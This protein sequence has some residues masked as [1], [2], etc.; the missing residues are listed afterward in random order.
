MYITE[1]KA[2][3]IILWIRHAFSCTN[4]LNL[5]KAKESNLVPTSQYD[6]PSIT[7]EGVHQCPRAWHKIITKLY[8][9]LPKYFILNFFIVS[10]LFRTWETAYF[11]EPNWSIY[12]VFGI[13]ELENQNGNSP[14][15]NWNRA[16][17]LSPEFASRIKLVPDLL[18]S[19]TSIQEEES[20]Q[21]FFQETLP[22][23]VKH[24]GL[25]KYNLDTLVLPIVSHGRRIEQIADP[26][27]DNVGA[28]LQEVK[29][30]DKQRIWKNVKN[31]KTVFKGFPYKIR[32]SPDME[33]GLSL[34]TA[35]M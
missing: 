25:S 1:A 29:F 27:L 33:A 18:F 30:S 26:F 21:V 17:R 16:R 31:S 13:R 24:F 28:V 6:D 9:I 5:E 8:E 35:N 2:K 15:T 12:P 23:I 19:D 10:L 34:C 32:F 20:K 3:M 22:K 14:K 4:A 11:I 7:T